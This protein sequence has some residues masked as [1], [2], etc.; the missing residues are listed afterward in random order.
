MLTKKK[1][2]VSKSNSFGV[3][4]NDYDDPNFG[5]DDQLSSKTKS[6]WINMYSLSLE[7]IEVRL[8]RVINANGYSK[9]DFS[10]FY[11]L[12]EI[13]LIIEAEFS[14]IIPDEIVEQ[15]TFEKILAYLRT[16]FYF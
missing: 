1:S 9:E 7:P 3:Y 2:Q 13:I 10:D 5:D 15:T 14:I 11:Y 16:I 12:L 4:N 6:F 8:E